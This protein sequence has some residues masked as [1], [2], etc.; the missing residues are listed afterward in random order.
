MSYDTIT[1]FILWGIL[2]MGLGD[3]DPRVVITD[4][5]AGVNRGHTECALFTFESDPTEHVIH[6]EVKLD[7]VAM[8]E[9]AHYAIPDGRGYDPSR[10]NKAEVTVLHE[11]CH[12]W[13][14]KHVWE[15]RGL[16]GLQQDQKVQHGLTWKGCMYNFDVYINKRYR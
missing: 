15:T 3:I 5:Y 7:S 14:Y 16:I 9:T 1:A 8:L 11:L 13:T 10:Y 6:C 4:E 2:H 12:I